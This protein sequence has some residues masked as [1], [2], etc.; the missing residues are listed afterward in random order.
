MPRQISARGSREAGL[1]G[2]VALVMA[3]RYTPLMAFRKMSRTVPALLP[4]AGALG[5]GGP[6]GVGP[7]GGVAQAARHACPAEALAKALPHPALPDPC[8]DLAAR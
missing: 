8:R 6:G 3:G 1:R 2:G 4:L 5:M 7:G